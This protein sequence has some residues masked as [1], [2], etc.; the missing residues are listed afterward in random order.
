MQE[1]FQAAVDFLDSRHN[2]I[3]INVGRFS[4]SHTLFF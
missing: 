2:P 1:K 3:D 4:S